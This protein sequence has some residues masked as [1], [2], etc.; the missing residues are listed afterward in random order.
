MPPDEQVWQALLRAKG[1]TI[2]GL[3]EAVQ[4]TR[5]HVQRLVTGKRSPDAKRVDLD[6][7]LALGPRRDDADP[8]YAIAVLA[9]DGSLEL[10]PA[11]DAQPVF[12]DRERAQAL[13]A[14]LGDLDPGI[15]AVPVWPAYAW[16]HTVAFHA[17]WGSAA[18]PRNVFLVDAAD[19]ELPV[20]VVVEELRSG[21]AETLRLR[22][23][24]DDPRR[25]GE[26]DALLE[27]A[28]R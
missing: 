15:C 13:A 26:V 16:R 7:A 19:G 22:A 5:Q 2:S 25:L 11:G 10:V 23:A 9:R 8:V 1:L 12:A 28:A 17:A 21:F 20:D 3:A 4:M 24:A 6:R 27:R 18:E 14:E